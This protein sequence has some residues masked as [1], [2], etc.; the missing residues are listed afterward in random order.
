M[1]DNNVPSITST[2]ASVRAN[3]AVNDP[4]IGA[5]N[6][7]VNLQA[8]LAFT[9]G[10]GANQINVMTAFQTILPGAGSC[11]YNL[12]TGAISGANTTTINNNTV[13]SLSTPDS[14]AFLTTALKDFYAFIP[15]TSGSN[16]ATFAP[17]P[18]NGFTGWMGGSGPSEGVRAFV[19]R[20]CSDSIGWSVSSSLANL[21]LTN[22]SST[23]TLT[24]Q[25]FMA[26]N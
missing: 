3:V 7:P 13:T 11:T 23:A 10:S 9:Q 8:S 1:A 4:T 5:Y 21:V 25:G 24:V 20:A 2:G 15:A 22:S 14:Q 16:S 17:G 18:T 6:I 12:N 26:G 19:H